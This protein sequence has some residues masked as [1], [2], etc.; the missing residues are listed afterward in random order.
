MNSNTLGTS[1]SVFVG[2]SKINGRGLFSRRAV[3]SGEIVGRLC[4]VILQEAS[5]RTIQIARNRHLCSD[6]IDFVNH[7]CRPNAYVRVEGDSIVLNAIKNIGREDD[8]ITID[9]NCSEF[10]LAESFMCRCCSVPNR[11]CGYQYL[12]ENNQDEYLHRI[13]RFVQPH[14]VQMSSELKKSLMIR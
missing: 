3:P 4:G 12:I 14:I 5:K 6:Y 7:C 13:A 8:E 9:Y 10:S 11:I 1:R 2:P